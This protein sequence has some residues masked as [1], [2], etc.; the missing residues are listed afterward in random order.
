M[1]TD[2][3]QPG[4]RAPVTAV[5]RPHDGPLRATDA[6]CPVKTAEGQ[7]EIRHRHHR[8]TQRQR[9]MLLLVDGR[10]SAAQVRALGLQAGATDTAFDELLD[11]GLIDAPPSEAPASEPIDVRPEAV[12][13]PTIVDEPVAAADADIG[14]FEH[15]ELE[16]DQLM[17]PSQPTTPR[18]VH[19]LVSALLPVLGAPIRNPGTQDVPITSENVL[20][21]ARRALMREVRA[22]RH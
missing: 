10:R 4:S 17:Q 19:A 20:E 5:W 13:E 18:R 22:R 12:D 14:A 15:Y 2:E 11:L 6:W 1:P 8:L 21:E 16:S 7:A 3:I 9:T